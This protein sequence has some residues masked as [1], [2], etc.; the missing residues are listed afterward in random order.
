MQKQRKIQNAHKSSVYAGFRDFIKN[1][2]VP[3]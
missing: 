1:S 2:V 3:T